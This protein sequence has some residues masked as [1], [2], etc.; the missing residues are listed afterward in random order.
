MFKSEY[1]SRSDIKSIEG[2][3]VNDYLD[4]TNICPV[5]RRGMSNTVWSLSSGDGDGG[6][7]VIGGYEVDG[8]LLLTAGWGDGFAVRRLN[9]DGSMT[10]LFH[11]SYALYRD[12][13][14][15]YNHIASMAVHKP[16]KKV[17]IMTMNVNGYSIID[18]SDTNN[19]FIEPRPSSQYFID[20]D[21]VK[22]DRAGNY[23]HNGLVCAGDW[24]YVGDYDSTHY[25]KYPRRNIVTGV[26]EVIDGTTQYTAGSKVIDRNGYR[27]ELLYDEVNDRVYYLPYYN[28]NFTVILNA[29]TENPEA[30]YV[31]MYSAGLGD[32]SYEQGLFIEDPTNSPNVVFVANYNSIVEIDYTGSFSGLPP[33]VLKRVYTNTKYAQKYDCHF[34]FGTKYQGLGGDLVDKSSNYPDFIMTTSDRGWN[35]LDGWIDLE[36]E[37][38]VGVY[39]SNDTTEDTTTLGRGR[40]YRSDYGFPVFQMKSGNG[41][42]YW[43]KVGYGHDGHGFRVW[44]DS[45]GNMLIDNYNL[46]YGDYTLPNSADIGKVHISGLDN[47]YT[48]SNCTLNIFV[49]NNGGVNWETYNLAQNNAHIFST[50]GSTLS[51][52]IVATGYPN[53]MPYKI[54]KPLLVHFSGVS[55]V[56][57]ESNIKY[58]VARKKLAGKK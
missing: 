28:A 21:G 24:I 18:Y 37:N 34:R 14:S 4:Q 22:I 3:L 23:Y 16:S 35:L 1:L 5:W 33:E 30:L 52:K 9:D 47:F 10:K 19:I 27:Y 13:T 26:Q 15:T 54:G 32:D 20:Q 12:T 42:K 38:L 50:I 45:V 57:R 29:S 44:D 2:A 25:K 51:V 48:P 7:R 43:V 39:R 46:V 58:K 56:E 11:D 49:S 31:D 40:S 17:V 53:K 36:N 55:R 41:T 6:D 8:D